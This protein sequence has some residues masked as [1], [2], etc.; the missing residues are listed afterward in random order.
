MGDGSVR[1][2]RDT[3]NGAIF[4]ALLSMDGGETIS[5]DF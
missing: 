5:D 2:L 1:F 4:R 3:I